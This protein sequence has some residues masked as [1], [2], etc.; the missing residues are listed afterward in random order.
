MADT[1]VQVAVEDWVRREWMAGEYGQRFARERVSLRSGGVFDFDAVSTDGKIVA[2][3][4]TSGARTA[5]GKHAVGKMLKV[6]SDIYF[7]LLAHGERKLM[8]LTEED[9]FK[10]WSKEL[11][12]G[13]VPDAITFVHVRIPR[14]L[15]EQLK[16]A[17]SRASREVSP[18]GAS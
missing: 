10:R 8:L 7:L 6:R 5:R 9:M 3:I 17:R 4:S 12:N 18:A 1:R 11:E 2:N 15:D 16:A 14:E 13:R